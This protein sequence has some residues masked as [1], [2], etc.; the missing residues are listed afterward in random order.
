MGIIDVI[1]QETREGFIKYNTWNHDSN[2]SKTASVIGTKNKQ[3]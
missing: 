1:V 2:T 3:Q